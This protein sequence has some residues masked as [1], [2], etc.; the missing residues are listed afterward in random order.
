MASFSEFAFITGDGANINAWSM[1]PDKPIAVLQVVH[2][3]MEHSARYLDFAHWMADRGMAV[4]MNDH[5][6]HGRNLDYIPG[7]NITGHEVHGHF[8]D[9]GGWTKCLES[10]HKLQAIILQ[11]H[12]G[13]PRFFLGHSLGSVMLRSYLQNYN[14]D[15]DGFILSGTML[16]PKPM[17]GTGIM[18]VDII[19]GL[20]GP[21]HRSGL[22]IKLG[23]GSYSKYF[24]PK[25][26]DFDWLSSDNAV[27]DAYVADPLC[28]FPCTT[29]YYSDFFRGLWE[30]MSRKPGEAGKNSPVLII[31]GEKDPTGHFGKDPKKIAAYYRDHGNLNV[32]LKLWTDG[33]HEMLNEVNKLEV[34]EFIL[35]WTN[36]LVAVNS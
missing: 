1:V 26:T 27:V 11:D 6:G 9:R 23:Y 15:I 30:N 16:Q 10:L 33:R 29:A 22:L 4:Y 14:V 18:L 34:W 7:Q 20:Y 3:M 19:R 17:L 24:K 5:P 28:G 35:N 8:A 2:G 21:K 36:D 31:G 12:P 32:G 13:L 25:R